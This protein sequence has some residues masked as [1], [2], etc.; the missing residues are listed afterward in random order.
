MA[1]SERKEAWLRIV[2]AIVSGI[3]LKFWGIAVAVAAV[4]NWIV[5]VFSGKRS[6]RMAEFCENW[7]TEYYRYVRYLT[8]VTNERPFPFGDLAEE[9][10]SKFTK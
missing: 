8:F 3:I 1:K 5:A 7:N 4:L 2:V 10:I 6:R 9:N